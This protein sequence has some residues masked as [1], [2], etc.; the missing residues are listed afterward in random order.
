MAARVT[1][2]LVVGPE[3]ATGDPGGEP[4]VGRLGLWL[5][6]VYPLQIV[7]LARRGGRSTRENWWQA[8]FLVLGKFPEMLGQAK[9]LLNRYAAGKALL[10]EYK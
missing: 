10:I 4:A 1:P 3:P 7:R 8:V 2:R 6:L 5:L 9:F